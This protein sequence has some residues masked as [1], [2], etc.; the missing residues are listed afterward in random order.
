M[1]ILK[2]F[3]CIRQRR[4]SQLSD[5]SLYQRLSRNFK[6]TL[7]PWTGSW[8]MKKKKKTVINQYWNKCWSPPSDQGYLIA[9][10]KSLHPQISCI[11]CK[12]KKRK[13]KKPQKLTKTSKKKKKMQ[14]IS[15]P[16]SEAPFA[17]HCNFKKVSYTI[18]IYTFWLAHPAYQ[19]K[20]LCMF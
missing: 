13:K 20:S 10:K 18:H 6:R 17:S 9:K 1:P 19:R 16:D 11:L 5:T 3:T 12:K 4:N 8:E 7:C 15:I 14:V 2:N